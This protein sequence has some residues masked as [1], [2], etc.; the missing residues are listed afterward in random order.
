MTV[1]KRK[2]SS[3]SDDLLL[4]P[5]PSPSK[6]MAPTK[7]VVDPHDATQTKGNQES[8]DTS[9]YKDKDRS[10]VWVHFEK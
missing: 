1:N 6:D 5:M 8:T 9:M 3:N 10:E 4:A 2:T 7:E